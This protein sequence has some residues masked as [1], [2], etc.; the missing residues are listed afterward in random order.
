[1]A[2]DQVTMRARRKTALTISGS[3][4]SKYFKTG[5]AFYEL[6]SLVSSSFDAATKHQTL[7]FTITNPDGVEIRVDDLAV[8]D[9]D[10]SD[11]D[12]LFDPS[13]SIAANSFNNSVLRQLGKNFVV[14]EHSASGAVSVDGRNYQEVRFLV[15]NL[16]LPP[17]ELPAARKPAV[18]AISPSNP[19][20]TD[21]SRAA[22]WAQGGWD[23]VILDWNKSAGYDE[24]VTEGAIPA[25]SRLAPTPALPID[26]G[27]IGITAVDDSGNESRVSLPH[28]VV[29]VLREKPATP[30]TPDVSNLW[31][32]VPDFDSLSRFEV[33][34]PV[35]L[36][37]R[38]Y[39][40][41]VYRAMDQTIMLTDAEA[42]GDASHA[43]PPELPVEIHAELATL[44]AVIN[45]WRR[46]GSEDPA[47]V[48][49]RRWREVVR[50]YQGLRNDTWEHLASLNQNAGAFA[51]VSGPLDPKGSAHTV[52]SNMAY[53]DTLEG[54][55]RNSYFYRVGA[56][57]KA[58]N[59]SDLGSST[60]PVKVPDVALPKAP[61]I[62]TVLGGDRRATLC[63][64]VN[65]EPGMQH[66]SVY[67]SDIEENSRDVRLMG[68]PVVQLLA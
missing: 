8:F 42:I 34:W 31:A 68:A 9:V 6:L 21:Y 10:T 15:Q 48:K 53:A 25:A 62:V 35:S 55:S 51:P 16:T 43:P 37:E 54:K 64:R 20:F 57:D 66:Y 63:W 23:G 45:N 3:L 61:R 50:T 1:M 38:E 65:T 52:G 30:A 2:G 44:D 19:L 33:N 58:G 4:S 49:L 18:L 5:G 17:R 22:T 41:Q 11:V 28:Q 39:F 14:I 12:V 26:T 56:L 29:S 47:D 40:Y 32:S 59:R 27:F 24:F 13:V 67:R 60:L 36:D 7:V 46:A